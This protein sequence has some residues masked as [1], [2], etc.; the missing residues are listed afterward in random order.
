MKDVVMANDNELPNK[1]YGNVATSNEAVVDA[2]APQ[3]L[4]R[5]I[6]LPAIV[7]FTFIVLCSWEAFAVTFQF[8]LYNGGPSS[9]IYGCILVGFGA[10]FVACSL[11]EL[12]SMDPSVGAQYRWSARFAP[13]A[14]RFFGLLQGWITIFAWIIAAAGPP[15]IISNIITSLAIFNYDG[16]SPK[17]WHTTLIMWGLIIV[18]FV[19]NLYFKQLLNVLETVGGIFHVLFFL[20]SIIVLAALARRSTNDYVWNT[21]TNDQSGW[22]NKG[23]AWG[24]G[25][26]TISFSVLGFDGALHMSDE[27]KKVETRVPRSMIIAAVSNSI[28]LFA[29]V[30]TVLYCI[31]DV[32]KVMSTPTALPL[33]EVFYEATGSKSATNF[34][35]VMPALVLFGALFNAFASVSRLIWVFAKD[36]GLPFSRHFAYLHPTLRLPVNALILVGVISFLLSLIYIGSS[37]AFNAIISLQAL[38]LAVSYVLPILFILIRKLGHG[39]RPEYGPFSLGKWG[40][41]CNILSLCYLFYIITWMPFPQFLPVTAQNMNYAG[42]LLGL[43][44]VGSMLHYAISGRKHFQVPVARQYLREVDG[45]K[46]VVA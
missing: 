12:S 15:A 30:L 14:P 5:Y 13:F 2:R 16:Y 40:I 46:D 11:A 43:V 45:R 8:A 34:L 3:M 6:N 25:L 35:V 27:V 21:L 4:E 20:V 28:M 39:A 38:G 7:N 29:F 44:I 32:T 17:G 31:G 33:I 19:F 24:L 42:P 9:M 22:E 18:P 10:S 41:P 1:E 36:Q 37:T 23:V 26:L